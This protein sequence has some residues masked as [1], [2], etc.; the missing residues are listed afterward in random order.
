MRGRALGRRTG[1]R[2]AEDALYRA[3]DAKHVDRRCSDCRGDN[4]VQLLKKTL[5]LNVFVSDR[6]AYDWYSRIGFIEIE[7]DGKVSTL[8]LAPSSSPA[9]KERHA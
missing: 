7:S 5:Y 8:V 1:S 2:M 3:G 9:H 4:V 6:A